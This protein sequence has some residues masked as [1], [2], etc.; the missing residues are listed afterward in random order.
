[1][2]LRYKYRIYP[3]QE[4]KLHMAQTFGCCRVVWN[5]A[6]R[7][8]TEA[9]KA[10]QPFPK[11]VD[12]LVITQAKKTEERAWLSEVSNIALQQSYRD[13]DK[14]YRQ[15]FASLKGKRKGKQLG[16]PRFKKKESRQS[17]TLTK[18]GFTVKANKL[19]LAKLGEVKIVIS[20][21]LPSEPSSVTI[22]KDTTDR[23]YASFVVEVED[24]IPTIA[25]NESVGIDLGLNH[26]AIL[27]TGEK[28]ENPRLHKKQLKRIKKASRQLNRCKKESNRRKAAKLRLAKIHAKVKDARTDFNHKLTTRL[29]RDNQA[30]SIEDLNVSGMVKNRKLSRAISDA[31]WFSFR[32]MLTAKC[33]RYNRQL[34]IV[35][36]WEATSQK[37]SHCGFKGGKKELNV[38]EWQCLN[39]GTHHDR[40]VNAAK[41]I[42]SWA[43]GH[44][45]QDKNGQSRTNKTASVAKSVDSAKHLE[46]S[47]L[48][49][50]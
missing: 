22:I 10:K 35:D 15:F 39:C 30:I 28:I 8:F 45:D 19:K 43:V 46:Y 9:F 29:V 40:D 32:E 27:S 17:Y 36:R 37:C 33:D 38:R 4:Q 41:N 21:P 13:L 26:F 44:T 25:P 3:N 42:E 31:G 1:M 12:K 2:K 5:D 24:T 6:L 16:R 48:S 11:A 50:F 14:T 7:L 20:R 23:Y 18:L 34:V 47:Q 49:L